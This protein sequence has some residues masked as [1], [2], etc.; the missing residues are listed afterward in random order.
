M[1]YRRDQS[2]RWIEING[3]LQSQ[4][5]APAGRILGTIRDITHVKLSEEALRNSVKQLGELAAIVASSD[6]VILK[7]GP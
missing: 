4:G 3:H 6:D 7:Q 1:I 5:S 2:L